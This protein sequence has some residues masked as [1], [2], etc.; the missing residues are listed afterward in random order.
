MR[1]CPQ[2]HTQYDDAQ[3]F[4][5]NDGTPLAGAA[6]N[7]TESE[8]VV[9]HVNRQPPAQLPAYPAA[10]PISQPTAEYAPPPRRRVWPVVIGTAL[11]TAFLLGIL[12]IGGWL[13]MRARQNEI[14]EN[15]KQNLPKH[16]PSPTPSQTPAATLTP[17]PT[18]DPAAQKAIKAD[19]ESAINDWK[20]AAMDFDL[21]GHVGYYADKVD[22]FKSG[23]TSAAKIKA[24]KEKAFTGYD[25]I[26]VDISDLKITP[27]PSGEKAVAVF[28]KEWRF[29][30]ETKTNSG[31]VQS[32]LTFAKVKGKWKIVGEK[33]LKVY[34]QNTE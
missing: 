15:T 26:S 16:T 10:Q 32:Q 23:G 12:G 8:T 4:C 13:Y 11:V 5:L 2:C 9:S 19:I 34:F 14:A 33:D 17:K 3:N 27:D 1:V 25:M 24:D 29:E 18:V 28:D 21:D 22:Y 31:A 7:W 30:S 20:Q 6:Q